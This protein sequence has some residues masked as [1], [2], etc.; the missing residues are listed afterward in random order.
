MQESLVQQIL[1]EM[2]NILSNALGPNNRR[3]YMRANNIRG[4]INWSFSLSPTDIIRNRIPSN[5]IGCT[6]C[7]K[8]FCFLAQQYGIKCNV[9]AMASIP[10]WRREHFATQGVTPDNSDIVINGHQIISVDFADGPRMFEPARRRFVPLTVPPRIGGIVDIGTPQ[11]YI[12]RAIV[13]GDKFIKLS[14]YWE[15]DNLYRNSTT[16]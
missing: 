8:L 3:E 15:L 2:H 7:A 9:V 5:V 13:P 10:D 1:D 11:E 4:D 14:S 16:L 12:I 6:G